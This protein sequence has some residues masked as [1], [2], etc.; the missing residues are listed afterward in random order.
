MCQNSLDHNSYIFLFVCSLLKNPTKRKS[1]SLDFLKQIL[2]KI[3][4]N[5]QLNTLIN[6]LYR[7][8]SSRQQNLIKMRAK[9]THQ[10]NKENI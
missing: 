10:N 8:L 3:Y 5:T 7:Y 1:N 6:K 9:K 2:S 4:I